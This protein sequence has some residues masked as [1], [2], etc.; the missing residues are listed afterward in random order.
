LTKA[1]LYNADAER[2][3]VIEQMTFEEISAR[4]PV[5]EKTLQRWKSKGK[6][7]EKKEQYIKSRQA[8]HDELYEFARYLMKSIK[9]DLK[10]GDSVDQGRFYTF[11]RILPQITRIKEYEDVRSKYEEK[12][13]KKGLTEDVIK[14]IEQEV[15]GI[16]H[17]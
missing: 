4:L 3:F 16:N 10:N 15:L 8:F 6:W 12:E 5:S 7:K 17:D 1:H 13:G 14:L 11:T 2:M 9:E